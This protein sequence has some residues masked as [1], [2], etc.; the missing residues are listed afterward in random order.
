MTVDTLFAFISD[1]LVSKSQDEAE[2]ETVMEEA[3]EL[4]HKTFNHVLMAQRCLN[5]L[6]S[7]SFPNRWLNRLTM[8]F[9]VSGESEMRAWIQNESFSEKTEK[10]SLGMAFQTEETS[11]A[12][13]TIA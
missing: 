6:Y 4:F 1:V 3:D 7:V 11:V 13:S 5:A 2:F 8:T 12:S 9:A 10:K